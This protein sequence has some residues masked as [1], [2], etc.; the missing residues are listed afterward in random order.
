MSEH[1]RA[2]SISL[3]LLLLV[4]LLSSWV[5][6]SPEFLDRADG[7]TLITRIEDSLSDRAHWISQV[8]RGKRPA[9]RKK[10]T[11]AA[12]AAG[13]EIT[14]PG[15]VLVLDTRGR[16][17]PEANVVF[18]PTGKGKTV[19]GKTNSRGRADVRLPL[20]EYTVAVSHSKYS[21]ETRAGQRVNSPDRGFSLTV[22][23][24]S[25]VALKGKVVN[26]EGKPLAGVSVSGQRN[27]FQQFNETAGVFL[28][29]AG[30]ATVLT[31]DKGNFRIDEVSIGSNSFTFSLAGYS[32]VE[33]RLDI[34]AGG[35]TKEFKTVLKRPATITGRIVDEELTPVAG[36]KV[37][38]LS[39]LPFGV[40]QTA[41]PVTGFVASSNA[42][43]EFALS[44]LY[45]SGYYVLRFEHAQYATMDLGNITADTNG[46]QV[47]MQRGGE[48]SGEIRF[49]DRPTSVTRVQV[50][51]RAVFNGTTVTRSV[52]TQ[53]SGQYAFQRL[54][55]GAYDLLVDYNGYINEPRGRV[56]SIKNKATTGVLVEIYEPAVLTGKV[57][58]AFSG[59]A[60]PGA[61]VS[62]RASY[63]FDRQRVRLFQAR[64]DSNGSFRMDKLPGGT[65]QISAKYDGYLPTSGNPADYTIPLGP[66]A[67]LENYEVFLS[68][69]GTV[70][71]QVV[72]EDG[73]GVGESEVQLYV[74]SGS[75]SGLNV[76]DLKM[77]TD[78]SG[79]FLFSDFPVGQQLT[80]YAS[81]TRP[82]FAKQHGDLIE[83]TPAQPEAITQVVLTP[84]GVVSGK[85]FDENNV[86]IYGA[87]VTFDSRE[88]AGDPSKSEFFTFTDMD[89]NYLLERC[90]PGRA[91][92]V[93]DREDYI[94][95]TK[96]VT[97]PE[98]RL[99]SKQNFRMLRSY[100]IRGVVADFRGTPIAGAVVLAA[101][102]TGT[103]GSGRNTTNKKGEYEIQGLG[104]GKFRLEATFSL[105][106]PE[107]KQ[108]YTFIVPEAQSGAVGIPI[109]CDVMP[110]AVGKVTADQGK[111][112]ESF[113]VT[114]K[115][116]MDVNP[117]QQFRFNLTRKYT[118]AAGFFRLM[119]VPRGLYTLKV[120]SPGYETWESD[121]VVIGPGNRTNLPPIRM[122]AASGILGTVI[123]ASTGKPVQGALVRILDDGEKEVET[124]NRIELQAYDR[125][126]ILEYL[127]AAYDED[128]K[129]DPDPNT[130]L[131]ARV[132]GNVV[133]TR[134]TNVYGKFNVNDLSSGMFTLEIEHPMFRPL[135]LRN[136]AVSRDKPVDLG[137]LELQPGGTIRGRVIDLEGNGIANTTVNISGE[138]Q[139]RNRANTDIAGNFV[140]RGIDNGEWPVSVI[141]TINGRKVYAWKKVSVRQDETSFV[142]FVLETSANV[143][144]RVHLPS[145]TV[146]SGTVRL[147]YV[148]HTGTVM[149]DIVY[150]SGLSNANYT[151]N[152]I[153]PG[154]Y[155]VIVNGQG[156]KGPFAFW[157]WLDLNRGRNSLPLNVLNASLAGTALNMSG[158]G[159]VP[160]AKLQLVP[161][162]IGVLL[163][164]SLQ[165]L[166]RINATSNA[167]GR[168]TFP[169]LQP[170]VHRLW[171]SGPSNQLNPVDAISLGP[172]QAITDYRVAVPD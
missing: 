99:L 20:G 148:D 49:L 163:P 86:P 57:L 113:T 114:L 64:A 151:I 133:T 81:A 75:F 139:G 152:N 147:Y 110:T 76:K 16:P 116:K 134:Q 169:Y 96:S 38:V 42:R 124:V 150:S 172:G 73:Q 104:R 28:D 5:V 4:G 103:T 138:I 125:T 137:D 162:V 22:R 160:G 50:Q 24:Q 109:D 171:A 166:L 33:S 126:D 97:I 105:D 44:K 145:G 83:L 146:R 157:S 102:L 11:T 120:E 161:D 122:K 14:G 170:V 43:G 141:A 9:P 132:R 45:S 101:P 164:S 153:P 140:F 37:S 123:S 79:F 107:G 149:D 23:L 80:M 30:Y 66:G 117:K 6:T 118:S 58:D 128:Y 158:S 36:V 61:N 115:A 35:I 53:G 168:F 65:Q 31:D 121:E 21:G 29:D 154:R 135:R 106:V 68:E 19:P 10:S 25:R 55:Y 70:K 78:G 52:M 59:E 95:Q 77:T 127:N 84:G 46:L 63:G 71:G 39:Y 54:Q 89:G 91:V 15:S 111:G 56:A 72:T 32:V 1:R 112:I 167:T 142:Q 100:N 87:K 85:I 7:R 51:A 136:I 60:I 2:L 165:S 98:G 17:V 93:V 8:F 40:G 41:L 48:I 18:K 90:T 143:T 155:F 92:L 82:G 130:R 47:E 13:K 26:E 67:K 129:Y 3:L 62:V 108:T 159:G 34:P 88:F 74:A 119:K 144:G 27:W 156:N 69:G 94:R 131:I 12:Q